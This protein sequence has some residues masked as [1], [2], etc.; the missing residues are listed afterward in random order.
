MISPLQKKLVALTH[1]PESKR[2]YELLTSGNSSGIS[3]ET[4]TKATWK[5][6]KLTKDDIE[7]LLRNHLL[8]ILTASEHKLESDSL[9][10]INSAFISNLKQ[11]GR[12]LKAI[13]RYIDA[14]QRGNLYPNMREF[15]FN[16]TSDFSTRLRAV[17]TTEETRLHWS[18]VARDFP[19]P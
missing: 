12:Q 3:S 13:E 4:K 10:K 11:L 1:T 18:G 9:P 16:F 19:E 8:A 14:S 2:V 17:L 7:E 15:I 5:E 6:L